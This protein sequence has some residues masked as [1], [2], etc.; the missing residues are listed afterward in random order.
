LFVSP[1]SVVLAFAAGV[2]LGDA[3]P[4]AALTVVVG[5]VFV[6]ASGV[7]VLLPVVLAAALG[8]R[9][10]RPLEAMR[11]WIARWGVHALVVVLV[12]LGVVQLV[13]GLTGLR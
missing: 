12:V 3:D 2:T 7:V 5:A 1:K 10:E 4:Q 8:P 9:A 6:L 11:S 13:I